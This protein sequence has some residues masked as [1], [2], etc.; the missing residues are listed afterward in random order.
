MT[1]NREGDGLDFYE[2]RQPTYTGKTKLKNQF[3]LL[4][5]R[6]LANIQAKKGLHKY[7]GKRRAFIEK[8]LLDSIDSEALKACLIEELFERDYSV[9]EN[10]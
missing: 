3:R 1:V 7:K 8:Y 9:F 6:E 10:S 2:L 5:R 4:W